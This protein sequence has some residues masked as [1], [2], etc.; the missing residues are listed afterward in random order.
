MVFYLAGADPYEK[1]Q[2]GGLKISMEGLTERDGI[3]IQEALRLKIPL[4]ILFAGG[5]AYDVMDTVKIHLN[6]IR[7]A[8]KYGRKYL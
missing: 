6:T 5:Y 7:L 4:V 1:D 2:L 8:Q 3:I